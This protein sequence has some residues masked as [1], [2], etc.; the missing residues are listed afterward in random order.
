MKK[1]WA[2]FCRDHKPA[3]I[4]YDESFMASPSKRPRCV[5]CGKKLRFPYRMPYSEWLA[6]ASEE[7]D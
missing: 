4:G 6:A 2:Y 3:E 5:V 7:E 1:R